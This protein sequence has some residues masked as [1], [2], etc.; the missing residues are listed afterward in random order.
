MRSFTLLIYTLAFFFATTFHSS[1]A[2]NDQDGIIKRDQKATYYYNAPPNLEFNIFHDF[3][4]DKKGYIW[5]ATERGLMRFEGTN[6]EMFRNDK[7]KK[8][9]ISDNRVNKVFCDSRGNIWIGTS[10]GLNYFNPDSETFE[11]VNLPPAEKLFGYIQDIAELAD[12][13]VIFNVAGNGLYLVDPK[14]NRGEATR[15]STTGPKFDVNSIYVARN[16]NI[17]L[18][19]HRG[20]LQ[21]I[22]PNGMLTEYQ[23]SS[24]H[25]DG[26]CHLQGDEILV[27]GQNNIW[28]VDTNNME[29]LA[30]DISMMGNSVINKIKADKNGNAYI[31][32][33]AGLW[34]IKAGENKVERCDNIFNSTIDINRLKI[35]AVYVADDGNLWIG[36]DYHGVVMA[37][38]NPL[39]F[40]YHP[41][42][43]I[44]NNFKGGISAMTT[45]KYG[46]WIAMEGDGI[47][48]IPH[49]N[50]P[51]MKI[52][53][54]SAVN[55]RSFYLYDDNSLFAAT[56]NDGLWKINPATGETS[57][58]TDLP[59]FA[60]IYNITKAAGSPIIYISIVGDGL[61][62]YN[63]ANGDKIHIRSGDK[64]TEHLYSNW[65]SSSFIDSKQRLWLGLFSGLSCYDI[66]S[67]TFK[68]I[69]Q[70][71]FKKMAINA[72]NETANGKILLGTSDGL[73]IYNPDKDKITARFTNAN[74]LADNDIRA[75]ET[76]NDGTVWIGTLSGISKY[77]PISGS[78]SSILGGYGLTEK[79][80]FFSSFDKVNNQMYFAG[81]LGFTVFHP[82]SVKTISIKRP[83]YIS[84]IYLNGK[85]MT[86]ADVTE[87]K[88]ALVPDS[89][90]GYRDLRISHNDNNLLIRVSTMDF[91]DPGNLIFESK[92]NGSEEWTVGQPSN[93]QIVIPK[94][95]PGDYTLLIR[96]YDN[97]AYSP[98]TKLHIHVTAPWYATTLA[99]I[100][101]ALIVAGILFLILMLYKKRNIEKLNEAKVKFF[102]N[103]SHEIRSPMTCIISPLESLLK[104]DLD[105]ETKQLL[106]N[107]HRNARRILSLANQLLEIRKIDK[108]KKTLSMQ[109]TDIKE[110][111][112]EIVDIYRPMAESKEIEINLDAPDYFPQVWIDR[113]N[114]DKIIVNLIT[115]AIK[116][117]PDGGK[118]DVIISEDEDTTTGKC[119]KISVID[120][121][122]GLDPK[123]ID[124]IFD[125]FYQG[126]GSSIGFGVGL[127]LAR[128][129]AILHHGSLDGAN[130]NDGVKGS[131]FTIRIPLGK[132]HLSSKEIADVSSPEIPTVKHPE[133]DVLINTE[134]SYSKP[135]PMLKSPYS[136][137]LLIVDDDK[138]LLDYLCG[139]YSGFSK[140]ECAT[141]GNEAMKI[142]LSKKIDIVISD[143]VMP[144][145]DGLTLL[146]TIKSNVNTN[147]IPVILLS[148]HD[149][150]ADRLS[151]WEHG[152]DGYVGKPFDVS[153]LDAIIYNFIE[154]RLRM[155]GKYS[156]AQNT[157]DKI[158]TPELKG[159]NEILLNKIV[160]FI[161]SH[162]DDSQLNVETLSEELSMSRAHLHRRLK[163]LT[164]MSPSDFIRNVKVKLACDILRT[165]DID[166]TQVAFSL[167]FSSQPHFST[168]FKRFT[169][170]TPSEYRAQV[171]QNNPEEKS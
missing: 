34:M 134:A 63:P 90:A 98:V 2:T 15:I 79:T 113:T 43:S 161:E 66:K 100:I 17:I 77:N 139:H 84:G 9:A 117:T 32:S 138:D 59:R 67:A 168:T 92:L 157:A 72:I 30:I 28:K 144:E 24:Y 101:Y 53:I 165:T 4:Q 41:L 125:R 19:T 93:S 82:S 1:A 167:G 44:L 114:F 26:I 106:K 64:G 154:N 10:N 143:V 5:I 46:T 13:T 65:I 68:P 170:M 163:E 33:N 147:H 85:K 156:G 169:G 27:Y 71:P 76:D 74:G 61:T 31:A 160:T 123:T 6:I 14:R 88:K 128:Q 75:I 129:L 99:E 149:E 25:I 7:N 116:Y 158:A 89:K 109:S 49:G 136:K 94:L 112:R 110:F 22:K 133:K 150:V 137:R 78:L 54:P 58:V 140:V 12:S 153:E 29:D 145:M 48:R 97:G 130:R 104:K 57:K 50:I 171:I 38:T 62:L 45:N 146:K 16:G 142:L 3:H 83:V 118:I 103:I 20:V 86:N 47:L 11:V 55:V 120:T 132:D 164:G 152:A 162:I 124:K 60:I 159:N 96:A 108:G 56:S 111:T 122:I 8:G 102:M 23:L 131:V 18:G 95:N 91:R 121:G 135:S 126:R 148:T 52:A 40:N 87:G 39:P 37:P 119:A 73:L 105:P 36:C 35:G 127:D 151:G 115:N 166:V 107:M 21:M 69:G 141:N 70:E 155:K 81:N 51:C 80:L 42:R